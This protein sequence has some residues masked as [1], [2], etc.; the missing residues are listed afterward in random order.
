MISKNK[1]KILVIILS[2][3]IL[4]AVGVTSWAVWFRDKG[5]IIS[6]DYPPLQ[7]DKYAETMA[8]DTSKNE[9][10]GDNTPSSSQNKV[11]LNYKNTVKIDL[12]SKKASVYFGNP[13][14]SNQNLML[15][16]VVDNEIIAVSGFVY[17]GYQI[18]TLDLNDS[19]KSDLTGENITGKFVVTFYNVETGEKSM[20]NSEIPVKIKVEK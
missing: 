20:V 19:I 16:L 8:V 9:N 12:K 5:D 4:I 13:L 15:Q 2:V 6:P 7:N 17:P 14:T 18:Q 11:T 3:L 1:E 10:D